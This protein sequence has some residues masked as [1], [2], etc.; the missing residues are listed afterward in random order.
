MNSSKNNLAVL[1]ER[2]LALG[3]VGCKGPVKL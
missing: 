2:R 1:I 3:E